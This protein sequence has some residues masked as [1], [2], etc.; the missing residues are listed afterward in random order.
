MQTVWGTDRKEVTKVENVPA[1]F[2]PFVSTGRERIIDGGGVTEL[3]VFA[4]REFGQLRMNIA[5]RFRHTA[6]EKQ[7]DPVETV[8]T[9]EM[10]LLGFS[11]NPSYRIDDQA[12]IVGSA[13]YTTLLNQNILYEG[14]TI[15]RGEISSL[16]V[17]GRFSF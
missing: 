8:V 6:P 10:D 11:I 5:S 7:T 12:E 3:K 17:G 14:E 15:K 2:V 16:T 1:P 4:E 9:D 13:A